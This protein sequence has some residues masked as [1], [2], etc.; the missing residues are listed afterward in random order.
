MKAEHDFALGETGLLQ[1]SGNFK[2]GVIR[3]E[4]DLAVDDFQVD[5]KMVNPAF[6]GKADGDQGVTVAL[7]VK[8]Q[9]VFNARI[10]A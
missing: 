7:A 6:V 8:Q 5:E 4:P 10:V 3:V 9:F 1:V 2:V